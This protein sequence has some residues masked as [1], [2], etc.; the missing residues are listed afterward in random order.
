MRVKVGFRTASR[1]NYKEFC[2]TNPQINLT[3]D[4]WKNIIYSFNEGFRDHILETG[5]KVKLPSGLGYF[6][7]RKRKRK[8]IVTHDGKDWINLPIDWQKTKK[9]KTIIYRFNHHTEGY[10]FGWIWFRKTCQRTSMLMPNLWYFKPTR[11]TSRLLAEYI[12]KDEKYQHIYQEWSQSER[13]G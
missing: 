4:D 11:V 9:S 8:R 2:K 12:N 5:E 3:Y 1:D 10:F 13:S 7:I 6:S